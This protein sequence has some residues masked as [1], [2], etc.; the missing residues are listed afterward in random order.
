MDADSMIRHISQELADVAV[1]ESAGDSFFFHERGDRVMPFATV[2]TGDHGD[3]ISEPLARAGAYRVSVGLTKAGYTALFGDPP[4]DRDERGVL[5]TG[6]DHATQD[7]VVP[8]PHYASQ[9][10]VCVVNPGPAT[11]ATVRELLADAH[12]Y[13]TRKAERRVRRSAGIDIS[14]GKS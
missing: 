14:D 2:V 12:A 13:A 9:Y 10:W 3:G 7:R 6:F 5:D 4:R 1:V 8:H 11:A